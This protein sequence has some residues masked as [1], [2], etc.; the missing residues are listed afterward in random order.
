MSYA[1]TADDIDELTGMTL[2]LQQR[3]VG[4]DPSAE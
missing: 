2:H 4:C 3:A 1:S